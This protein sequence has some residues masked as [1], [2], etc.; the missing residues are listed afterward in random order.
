MEGRERGEDLTQLVQ[1]YLRRYNRELG[2]D[3]RQV[4]PEALERLSVE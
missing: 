1:H 4:A 2:R 3:V